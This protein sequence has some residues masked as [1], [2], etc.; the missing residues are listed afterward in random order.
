MFRD[1]LILY[2]TLFQLV[3]SAPK[4]EDYLS[5]FCKTY[6]QKYNK[7]ILSYISDLEQFTSI[8]KDE[9]SR[10]KIVENQIQIETQNERNFDIKNDAINEIYRKTFNIVDQL[11]MIFD[12]SS[13][14]EILGYFYRGE[15]GTLPLTC[16]I[17]NNVLNNLKENYILGIKNYSE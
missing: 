15:K 17:Q 12:G 13:V 4:E 7:L 5:S 8:V 11:L 6:Q 14:D 10:S 1:I 16:I 3:Y 9:I 2:L